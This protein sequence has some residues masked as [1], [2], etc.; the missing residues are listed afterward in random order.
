M[1]G[2]WEKFITPAPCRGSLGLQEQGL[3]SHQWEIQSQSSVPSVS[4][5]TGVEAQAVHWTA[6]GDLMLVEM[7]CGLGLSYSVENSEQAKGGISPKSPVIGA[8]SWE[9]RDLVVDI[10][11]W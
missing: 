8:S 4:H 1:P 11:H 3:H 2:H 10:L 9:T 7:V 6:P 5:W